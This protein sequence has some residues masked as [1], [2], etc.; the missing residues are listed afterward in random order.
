LTKIK[1]PKKKRKGGFSNFQN[2][3]DSSG[4]SS[5]GD[6]MNDESE[7][8]SE[9]DESESENNSVIPNVNDVSNEN[10]S[11]KNSN[12]KNNENEGELLYFEEY[13]IENKFK[14]QEDIFLNRSLEKIVLVNESVKCGIYSS[15]SDTLP[16]GSSC[17]D[18]VP[19]SSVFPSSAP[20]SS[21]LYYLSTDCSVPSSH[22]FSDSY[23]SVFPV[24]NDVLQAS[25]DSQYSSSQS[26]DQTDDFL[27][28]SGIP[29]SYK[30]DNYNSTLKLL[31]NSSD[32]Y[33]DFMVDVNS[34]SFFSVKLDWK[35][36]FQM[37]NPLKFCFLFIF[38]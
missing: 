15:E 5:C 16:S 10:I 12:Y 37:I 19:L 30:F 7:D 24:D 29:I 25:A 4:S 23:N 6:I 14:F 28:T 3:G 9:F 26:L 21:N 2:R 33:L 22:V 31:K 35:S 17:N 27:F 36:I 13:K 1:K 20:S 8:F 18:L 32:Y 34:G 11:N 38:F